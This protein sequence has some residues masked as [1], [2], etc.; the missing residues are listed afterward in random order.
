M[1]GPKITRLGDPA[2]PYGRK[3]TP[4]SAPTPAQQAANRARSQAGPERTQAKPAPKPDDWSPIAL[5]E[6]RSGYLRGIANVLAGLADPAIN[7]AR[8]AG[9]AFEKGAEKAYEKQGEKLA[10][11]ALSGAGA[12]ILSL[13]GLLPPEFA[14][15]VPVLAYLQK[16]EQPKDDDKE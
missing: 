15:I 6:H 12:L 8:K 11:A 5:P 10:A 13:A 4:T 7:H 16:A 1:A 14:W 2:N 3:G 9:A